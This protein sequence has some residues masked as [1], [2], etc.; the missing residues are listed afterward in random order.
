MFSLFRT[1][2][3]ETLIRKIDQMEATIQR[4]AAAVARNTST[5]ASATDLIGGLAQAIR[6]A[7]NDPEQIAA[8]AN[9]LEAAN[10]VLASAVVANTPAAEQPAEEPT[11][12]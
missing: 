7:A 9:E 10:D 1:S 4:L 2:T 11:A 5:I 8:L 3:L 12:A 6:D